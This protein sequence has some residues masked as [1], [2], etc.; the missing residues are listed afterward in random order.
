MRNNYRKIFS[1]IIISP[2]E[3]RN[4][5]MIIARSRNFLCSF[6]VFSFFIVNAQ[7]QSSFTPRSDVF[8]Q[9]FYWNSPMGG[10]WYDSLAQLAPRLATAGFG[11]IWFPPPVKGASGGYSMGYDPYDHFDFGEYNQKGTI[12]TRFGSRAELEQSITTFHSAGIEVYA[13]VVMRHM[14]GGESS[15]PYEC[16]PYYNGSKIVPDNGWLIFNYP[17]GSGRF[18]KSAAEFYP[19]SQDC[20]VDARFVATDPAFRFGEWLDHYKQSVRDSLIVWGTY[21]RTVLKYDG[22]RIDAVKPIDPWFMAQFLN[23]TNGSSFAVAEFW[24]STAEI[25]DWLNVAKNQNGAHVTMFDFP[26]RYTLK[27]MCNNTGG[28]FDMRTLDGAGLAGAGVSGYDISTFVENHDVDRIGYDGSIGSGHDPVLTDKQLAY[29]YIIFSEGHPCVFFKDYFMYGYSGVIDTLIS[30]RRNFLS[31]TTTRRSGLNPY[32]LGGS[33]TQDAMAQD[34]YVARRDGGSGKPAAYLVINDHPTG[35]RGVWVN[36]N[37]PNQKFKDYTRHNINDNIKTAQPDGRIDLWAPPRSYVIYVPR[38]AASMMITHYSP[39]HTA[40]TDEYIVLFNNSDT[41]IDLDGHEI[42]YSN[43]DGSTP[44]VKIQWTT[45]TIIP[46]RGYYLC[47][48]TPTVSVGSVSGRSADKTYTAFASDDG[49][50]A[51]R[52]T[53]SGTVI[54]ALATGTITSYLFGLTSSKSSSIGIG[55]PGAFQLSS[56]GLTYT[57]SGNNNTDYTFIA[58]ENIAALPNSGSTALP[59]ELISFT[60]TV[61]ERSVELVWNTATE[62]NNYGFEVERRAV[63]DRH[64]EGDGHLAWTKIGF[65][66]GNG[67]TNAPKSYSFTDRSANGKTLYRLKQIDRDGKFEYSQTVEVTAAT[68]PKEFALEQN[69]P[70]PFNPTTAISYQLSANSFTTLKIYDALG[71]EAATLVNEVKEAGYYSAPFDGS[72]LSS[73]M[74]YARLSSNGKTQIRKIV[75]LK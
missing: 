16:I 59:V 44:A 19:N 28:T 48:S 37:F 75:L 52:E 50:I 72:K 42:A 20:F 70:N 2:T 22:F 21:L 1:S 17:N 27:D 32:Y 13:D 65:V 54:Y 23:G 45:T 31:G 40:D 64:L 51:F 74:Y 66:E 10:I 55:N 60:A 6:I 26:L 49:Q 56:S 39:R 11:G 46:P 12:E 38:N 61:K 36:S 63:S 67:T 29:A 18:K 14:M 71:R 9:G 43:G 62:T 57:R 68:A 3:R 58:D 7:A 73:G 34:I 8:M 41:E 15:T 30:I 25:G 5:K 24:G 69:Y 53:S 4:W 35:W 47:A 33:G